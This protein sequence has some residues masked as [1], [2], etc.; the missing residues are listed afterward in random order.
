MVNSP[1]GELFFYYFFLKNCL[2]LSLLN[3]LNVQVYPVKQMN[4]KKKEVIDSQND[5][6]EVEVEVPQRSVSPK[7][8]DGGELN[9]NEIHLVHGQPLPFQVFTEE[10]NMDYS[11]NKLSEV[12]EHCVCVC[13][14]VFLLLI[15]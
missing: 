2:W 12:I 7:L 3:A 11:D 14:C 5:E 4:L 6:L 1:T 8:A 15:G 13:V 9:S 10:D